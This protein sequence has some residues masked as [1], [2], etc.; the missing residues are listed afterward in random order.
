MAKE[1]NGRGPTRWR[2]LNCRLGCWGACVTSP[3]HLRVVSIFDGLS[4]SAESVG[5][6]EA[7][8]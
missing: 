2:N 3:V 4:M 8:G 5:V 1:R 7:H 6:F